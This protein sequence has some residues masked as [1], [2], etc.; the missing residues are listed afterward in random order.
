MNAKALLGVLEG[1]KNAYRD[2]VL[3]NSGAALV[4]AGKAKDLKEGIELAAQSIDS[5]AALG[6]LQKVI[7]VS[8]DNTA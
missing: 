6:V 3:L 7:A 1:D 8:N 4:I 5:G 2:I